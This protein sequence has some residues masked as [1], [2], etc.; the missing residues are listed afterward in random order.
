[1]TAWRVS[2]VRL[3]DGEPFEAGIDEHGRWAG[4]AGARQ[5]AAPP[6]PGR[7]L[8][9]GLVDAHCHLTVARRPDNTPEPVGLDTAR[10]RLA[11]ARAAGVTTI[12][13]T[14]SP[15]SV[16]LQ[17]LA[18]PDGGLLA[19]GRFLAPPQQ[20][21]PALHEPVEP[22]DL[23]AAALAE[24]ERG[25]QW[26]KLVGDFPVMSGPE[27]TEPRPT[28][29]IADVRGLVEAAHAAGARV[30][31]HTTTRHVSALIDAGI[32]SVEHGT[33]L[34]DDDLVALAA[35]GGA[36]TPTVCAVLASPLSAAERRE[37]FAHLLP[38]AAA[39]GVTLM[40]GTD[41]VGT[42]PREVSL[43]V[44]LGLTPAQA[45]SAASGAARSFLGVPDFQSG[46]LADVV[47]YAADPRE[48]PEVLAHPAAVV[49]RGRRLV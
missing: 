3:P 33:E 9:S 8:L 11:A 49:A 35:R 18:D 17:L 31:A 7:F 39:L 41:V 27:R 2:G 5:A 26:V 13:D 40:A 34:S 20:Y 43:L 15:G 16:S 6:L 21:F 36:W 23:V 42:L 38:R 12:R 19:C 24:I 25:A 14:G 46:H 10:E 48:D 30:A 44:E 22:T 37:H 28:Y 4:P 45:L 32:D 1:M 29:P 47:T